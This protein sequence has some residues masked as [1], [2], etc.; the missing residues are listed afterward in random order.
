MIHIY[1]TFMPVEVLPLLHISLI[2][3]QQLPISDMVLSF[4]GC[5]HFML[6]G[7]QHTIAIAITKVITAIYSFGASN[8]CLTQV[9]MQETHKT[10]S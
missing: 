7:I 1:C 9:H 3:S 4:S 10:N 2:N 6:G 5:E 8:S